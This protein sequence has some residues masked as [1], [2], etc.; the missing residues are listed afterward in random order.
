MIEPIFSLT[1]N[2]KTLILDEPE[3]GVTDYS[4]WKPRIT[5]WKKRSTPTTSGND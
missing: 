3:Y 2:G 4:V 5:I 1:R